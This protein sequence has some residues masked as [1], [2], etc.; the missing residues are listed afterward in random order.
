MYSFVL[1]VHNC[2]MMIAMLHLNTVPFASVVIL[3]Q[4]LLSAKMGLS[5]SIIGTILLGTWFNLPHKLIL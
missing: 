3:W 5:F 2:I 4:R 1:H